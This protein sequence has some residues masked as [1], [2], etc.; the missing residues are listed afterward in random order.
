MRYFLSISLL[1]ATVLHLSPNPADSF[2]I[3]R[4]SLTNSATFIFANPYGSHQE[5]ATLVS[6]VIDAEEEE[7]DDKRLEHVK[8]YI[9]GQGRNSEWTF[10][11]YNRSIAFLVNGHVTVPISCTRYLA[12]LCTYLL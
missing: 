3:N 9:P 7:E 11:S 6:I 4:E 12:F 5:H 8:T 10:I 2:E 1:L